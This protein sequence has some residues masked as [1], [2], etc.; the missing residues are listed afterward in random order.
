MN[1]ED[2]AKFVLENILSED[3]SDEN[4][5]KKLAEILRA[6]YQMGQGKGAKDMRDKISPLLNSPE[7]DSTKIKEILSG[8][9]SQL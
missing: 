1:A 6:I 9:L 8:L 3:S 7:S 4:K 2:L 5:I